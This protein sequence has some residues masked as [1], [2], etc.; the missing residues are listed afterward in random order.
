L[1][2]PTDFCE[3]ATALAANRLGDLSRLLFTPWRYDAAANQAL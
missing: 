1:F 2:T 3:V